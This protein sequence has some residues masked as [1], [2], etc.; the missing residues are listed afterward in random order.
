MIRNTRDTVI[1]GGGISGLTVAWHLNKVGVDV[2]LLEAD[3]DVG[4][5]TRTE[6]RDGF[7]LE[8]GPFNVIVRDPAFQALLEGVAHEVHVV[9]ASRAARIRYLYRGER[10]V[11][12][13]GG[14]L[15]LATT[16]LLSPGGRLRLSRGLLWSRRA[17]A[18][19]ETIEQVATRRL[20]RQVSDTFISAVVAGI[21]AGDIRRLSLKAC[22]P[23]LGGIDQR[24]R[25]LIGYGLTAPFRS[26]KK[27][28]PK[29]RWRGLVSIEG[30]LGTLTRALARPLGPRLLTGCRAQAIRAGHDGY[31]VDFRDQGGDVRKL[32]CRRLV[33][34][35]PAQEAAALLR[36]LAGDAA[37]DL[38][39]IPS[40]SLV[41]LN[42]GFRKQ[43]VGHPLEGFGFLAP[44]DEVGFPLMGVLWA[45]SIFP[46]HAPPEHRL[47]RVFIGG[48][49]DPDAFSRS[50]DELL[51][52]AMNALRDLLQVSADPMLIDIC[53]YPAA[54]PQYELGHCERS[55]RI[56][57]AVA[58]RPGLHLAGNYLGGVSLNDCIR[59]ATELAEAIVQARTAGGRTDRPELND[60]ARFRAASE[61]R[62]SARAD[63]PVRA[64]GFSPRGFPGASRG[65]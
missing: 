48:A 23:N 1:I 39:T 61:P 36:P 59:S 37:G 3:S 62:A 16:P 12:V 45:D 20:G 25:S 52:T 33:I 29:R 46:Q 44:H 17:A 14:P 10:L 30:G 40:S 34:A 26:K 9:T 55:E 56:R 65:L 7:L 58:R 8:K 38:E 13:P 54:I 2:G 63:S 28:A 64:A 21:F 18:L 31:E 6:L 27:D 35:A 53:R 22:F 50:D 24:A 41:V 11:A 47:L 32:S 19:E 51:T 42:L 4:G 5:C 57:A 15:A 43:C 49:R 60:G